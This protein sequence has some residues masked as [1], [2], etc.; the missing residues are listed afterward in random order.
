[1]NAKDP[2]DSTMSVLDPLLALL[3]QEASASSPD[4]PKDWRLFWSSWES[5][6]VGVRDRERAGVHAPL[7]LG[8]GFAVDYLFQWE[9]GRISTGAAERVGL[10]DPGRFLA[11]ARQAAFD[12]PD[13]ANFAGPA[14]MPGTLLLSDEVVSEA[15]SGGADSFAPLLAVAEARAKGWEFST[16]SG[17]VSASVTERGVMTSRGLS[18]R[19]ESSHAGYSFWYEGRTG[20][21]HSS[22]LPIP[23]AE[24]EARLER[25]CDLVHRLGTPETVF[26]PGTM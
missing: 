2:R 6:Q 15:R 23:P 5:S 11:L 25:A 14:S 20:D 21:G 10:E 24:A 22:R 7:S 3:S 13:G 16:W 8:R 4:R 19:S 17:S 1:M 18:A 12:D 9:D 26:E